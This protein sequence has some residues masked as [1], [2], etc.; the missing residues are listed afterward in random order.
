MLNIGI[1]KANL[2]SWIEAD[3]QTDQISY[4]NNNK[5]SLYV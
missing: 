2:K 1:F 5:E 3:S 4:L